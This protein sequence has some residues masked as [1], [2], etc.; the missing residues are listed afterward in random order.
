MQTLTMEFYTDTDFD[1]TTNQQVTLSKPGGYLYSFKG[2]G[3]GGGI[4]DT[5]IFLK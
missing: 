3:A 4:K 1:P 2:Y 5:A